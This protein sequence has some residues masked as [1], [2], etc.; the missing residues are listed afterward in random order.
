MKNIFLLSVLGMLAIGCNDAISGEKPI[1]EVASEDQ[2]ATL[3]K[4]VM[5]VH[6]KAMAQMNEMS[7]LRRKLK[8]TKSE[9][10]DTAAYHNA[11][12]DLAQAQEA[13]M[14]WMR[15]FENPDEMEVSL[16]EKTRYLEDQKEKIT[17]VAEYTDRSINKAKAVLASQGS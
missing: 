4:E 5:A 8:E 10:A 11:Y 3:K 16:K 9:A 15:N 12:S 2:I 13:M 6:D 1:I 14:E 17:D 7:Q